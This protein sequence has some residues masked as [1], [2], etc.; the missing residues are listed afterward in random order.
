MGFRDKLK[1]IFIDDKQIKELIELKANEIALKEVETIKASMAKTDL[2]SMASYDPNRE[3]Y[4]RYTGMG[5]DQLRH[6][7]Y[8][9]DHVL[10]QERAYFLHKQSGLVR[11][12][13]SDTKNFILGEGVTYSVENDDDGAAKQ[14]IDDFWYNSMNQMNIRLEKRIEALCLLGEQCWP[15]NVNKHTGRVF[16]SYI[17]P[18]NISDVLTIR[19]FPEVA[20]GVKLVGRSGRTGSTMP[21]I[22]ED[23]NFHSSEYGRLVGECFFF[24]VN[25]LPNEPR[26]ISDLS[27]LFDFIDGFEEGLFDE[28]DRLKE[29]KKYIWDITINGANNDQCMDYAKNH[30]NPSAGSMRVHNEN[31]KWD[32]VAPDLKIQDNQNFYN[33]MKTYISACMN[34]PDSWFGSG[35]KAYQTEADLMGEPT[36]KSLGSRQRYVK[37]MIE[38]VLKFVV[39]QAI[40]HGTLKDNN[41]EVKVDMPEVT[42]KDIKKTVDSLSVLGQSLSLVVEKSWLSEKTAARIYSSVAS[43][44]GVDIDSDKEL[45]EALKDELNAGINYETQEMI[46]NEVLERLKAEE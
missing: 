24:S 23:L 30:A 45:E 15:V 7:L 40:I 12:F 11:R 4:K 32:V 37:Y 33:L 22:R 29:L 38:Y 10:L 20:A 46:I 27:H 8:Q 9:V 6:D 34:R 43:Q 2:L 17:D 44:I 16:I 1:K 28:L 25:N 5:A 3:G 41:Y 39:D 42:T 26:G 14:I 36:F 31:I 13:I 18:V 21:V 19:D 35:G